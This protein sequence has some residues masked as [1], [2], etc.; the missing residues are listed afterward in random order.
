MSLHFDARHAENIIER[1]DDCYSSLTESQKKLAAWMR[2]HSQEAGLL[3]AREIGLQVGVSE[4]TVHRFIASLGYKS[5]LEM[6]VALQQQ[7]LSNRTVVRFNE[8]QTSGNPSET[9]MTEAIQTELQNFQLTFHEEL[10]KAVDDAADLITG[11]DRIYVAGWR[12]GL[13]VSAPLSYQLNLILGNT[14]HLP[15][16]GELSERVAYIKETDVVI[17][18]ALPRYCPI[19]LR[20]IKE[21]Q[22]IGAKTICFTDSPISPF[23]PL[24]DVSLLSAVKSTGFFDSYV[25]PLMISQL[26][27]QKIANKEPGRVR[28]NLEQ[29]EAFFKKWEITQN[30]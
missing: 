25:T 30:G 9:L 15:A 4:A 21:A 10:D 7:L 26:L 6:K 18:V 13:A 23:Y 12:N 1:I 19:T 22:G 20:V 29:Q 27:V 28:G 24:A 8:F 14:L 2:G 5:Y 16:G 17:A 11:A 3:T